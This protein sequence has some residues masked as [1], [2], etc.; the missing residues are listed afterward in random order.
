MDYKMGVGAVRGQ[1]QRLPAIK[2]AVW[3]YVSSLAEGHG[4][5]QVHA[6]STCCIQN[7]I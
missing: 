1:Q 2:A 4:C 5:S 7:A 3:S 6:A